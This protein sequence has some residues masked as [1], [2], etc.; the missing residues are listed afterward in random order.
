MGRS[1][2][3]RG[4]PT[5][6]QA[7]YQGETK[8]TEGFRLNACH[9]QRTWWNPALMAEAYEHLCHGR[10]G[11][12]EGYWLTLKRTHFGKHPTTS[13]PLQTHSVPILGAESRW[14]EKQ[15]MQ[16]V[17]GKVHRGKERRLMLWVFFFFFHWWY[18]C[19]VGQPLRWKSSFIVPFS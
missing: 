1:H 17:G 16:E 19:Q 9:S 15:K 4:E 6:N 18:D 3:V 8:T 11:A 14:D 10:V 7:A 5:G 12:R 13:L 2:H